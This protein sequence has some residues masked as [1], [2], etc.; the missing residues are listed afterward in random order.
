MCKPGTECTDCPYF[1]EVET[2]YDIE[3]RCA[4]HEEAQGE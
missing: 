4:R 2:E 1:R 3:V